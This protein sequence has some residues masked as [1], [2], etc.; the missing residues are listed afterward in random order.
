MCNT[1]LR[2]YAKNHKVKLWKIA[3]S[4]GI[5]DTNFSK[6]LRYELSPEKILP[7]AFQP[8]VGAAVGKAVK[9]AAIKSGVAR[10]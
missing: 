5:T 10:I 3:D 8:G 2:E 1:D 9:E 4:L 6:K 7:L